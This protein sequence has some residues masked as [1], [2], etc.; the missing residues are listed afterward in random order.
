M[1]RIQWTGN[2]DLED[3]D[4]RAKGDD[5]PV[6]EGEAAFLEGL[7]K[8]LRPN[9]IA[10]VGTG[11]GRS[12]KAFTEAQEWLYELGITCEVYTCDTSLECVDD[13]KDG[14]YAAC[15]VHGNAESLSHALSGRKI[16]LL[17]IDGLH[18]GEQ[19]LADLNTLK[20]HLSKNAVVLFHD[21]NIPDAYADLKEAISA[22]GVMVLPT[23]KGIGILRR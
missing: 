5:G 19:A 8:A 14:Y 21:L 12:L 2:P 7:A 10:E 20:P 1:K 11:W 4:D 15:V 9:L 6:T 18:T 22:I 13:A 16:D 17:F 23:A 3:V